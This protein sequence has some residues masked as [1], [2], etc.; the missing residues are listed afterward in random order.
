MTDSTFFTWAIDDS[1][2]LISEI[3]HTLLAAVSFADPLR[4]VRAMAE[5]RRDL[6]L[7]ANFEFK[8]NGRLDDAHSRH[9]VSEGFR[10]L[11]PNR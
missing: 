4:T 8:W 1:D 7:P 2:V 11:F 5:L 6:N 3:P 9:K 10:S